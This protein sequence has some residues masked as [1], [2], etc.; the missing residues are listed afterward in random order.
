MATEPLNLIQ[1]QSRLQDPLTVTNQDLLKYANG[2]NPEVPSF[3][4]LIEMNRRKQIEDTTAQFQSANVP[5]VKDQLAQS[6]ISPTMTGGNRMIQV[7]PTDA[8]TGIINPTHMS[9]PAQPTAN[10]FGMPPQVNMTAPP[11]VPQPPPTQAAR[12]G[13][14]TL[15]V[16]HFNSSSYAGGG[17]VAFGDPELNP[18]EDQIVKDRAEYIARHSGR[19]PADDTEAVKDL[20]TGR[21]KTSGQTSGED[22]QP[23]SSDM[24][25]LMVDQAKK[26]QVSAPESKGGP[27]ASYDIKDSGVSPA[28]NLPLYT[29][30]NPNLRGPHVNPV[31]TPAPVYERRFEEN[32]PESGLPSML[33]PLAISKPED[34]SREQAYAGIKESQRMAGVSQDPY[35][36]VKK[37]QD[38]LEARQLAEYEQGGIDRLIAQATAFATA[39]PAKGFGVAAAQ[40]SAASRALE[41]EQNALRTQQETAAITVRT[42][43]AKE[44]DAHARGD[45]AAIESSVAERQ[46]AQAEFAKLVQQQNKIEI[47]M[48]TMQNT[49][50]HYK[51]QADIQK[52]SNRITDSY[53]QGSLTLEQAKNQVQAALAQGQLDYHV[54]KLVIDKLEAENKATHLINEG[55]YW[56]GMVAYHNTMAGI[57]EDTRPS[58]EDK[59]LTAVQKLVEADPTIKRLAERITKNEIK[60]GSEE[61]ATIM[62]EMRRISIPF[63]KDHKLTP[64]EPANFPKP[65]PAPVKKE[66]HLSDLNP[67]KPAA[68][69]TVDTSGFKYI[70]KDEMGH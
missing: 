27:D 32:K 69:A 33:K 12:G 51:D 5:S 29:E 22:N 58:K 17:I 31:E 43:M 11:P 47:D 6:L 57:A 26:S 30:K 18:D 48:A 65:P 8:P 13:L 15:P 14:M 28:T 7:N 41:K 20:L 62:E 54:A 53:H 52:E 9:Q 70:G 44:Q 60:I 34:L 39:D 35:A 16:R 59:V 56:R 21:T 3:L 40:S 2:G 45:A 55:Q 49:A 64:P 19:P 61:Y 24:T 37:R 36:D 4:A 63:Y 68:P 23:S 46:K 10:P 50:Q 38:A 66:F 25:R 1:V 42:A 67:F